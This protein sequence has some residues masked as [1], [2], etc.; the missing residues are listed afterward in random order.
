MEYLT[1][2]VAHCCG[3]DMLVKVVALRTLLLHK[4][5]LKVV[6]Q[7]PQGANHFQIWP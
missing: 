2:P 7:P 3:A 6:R 1:L 5:D 4:N